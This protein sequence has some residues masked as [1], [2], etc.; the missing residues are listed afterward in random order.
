MIVNSP[1]T[2]VGNATVQADIANLK[3]ALAGLDDDV[4]AFLPAVA[5]G[6]VE[7]W[8]YNQH[9]QSDEEFLFALADALHH[10]Q[11]AQA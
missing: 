1:I 10:A 3:A 11:A 5:P 8:L 9:Y 2:Y 6:T 7:H 4:E